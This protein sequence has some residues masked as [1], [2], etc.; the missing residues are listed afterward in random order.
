MLRRAFYS[1]EDG[2]VVHEHW[3]DSTDGKRPE[4]ITVDG[5]SLVYDVCLNFPGGVSPAG[6][7]FDCYALGVHP[8]QRESAMRK[9]AEA[10]VPTEYNESGDP[11]IRNPGHYRAFKK[12]QGFFDKDAGYGDVCPGETWPAQRGDV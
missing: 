10:G 7:P 1:N 3:W 9:C 6:Y 11:V 12:Q 2:S 4:S 5:A 8:D